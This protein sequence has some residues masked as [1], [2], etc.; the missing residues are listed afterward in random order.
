MGWA[1]FRFYPTIIASN[2]FVLT[3]VPFDLIDCYF[4]YSLYIRMTAWVTVVGWILF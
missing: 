4:I 3:L 1:P 2:K